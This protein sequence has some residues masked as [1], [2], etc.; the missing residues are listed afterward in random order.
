MR[1]RTKRF[2]LTIRAGDVFKLID[3]E[4]DPH[5]RDYVATYMIA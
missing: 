5:Y 3:P 4:D 2:G 1:D